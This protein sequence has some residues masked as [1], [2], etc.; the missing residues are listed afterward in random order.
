MKI[1]DVQNVLI[2]GS[3]TMGRQ[4]GLQCVLHGYA[5]TLYDIQPAALEAAVIQIKSY[6]DQMVANGASEAQVMA[7][8]GRINTTAS[9]A[10]AAADADLV[11]ES[12]LENPALKGEVFARLNAVCPAHTIFTTNTSSLK[13]SQFAAATGRPARFCAFHFHQPVWTSNVVDIMPHPGTSPEV[14]DLLLAFARC[15]DQIPIFLHKESAN[16]VFN[17]MLDAVLREAV[18]LAANDVASVEDI[19]RAWMGV[20]KMTIGPFGILDLVGLDLAW[21][22]TQRTTRWVSFLPQVRRIRNLIK[23]RVVQGKLGV[24]SKHGFYTYPHPVY[25]QPGF[26]SGEREPVMAPARD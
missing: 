11:S 13:P 22:I 23:Q 15:I 21:D 12:V 16:Y 17:A 1:E 5:V 7:A 2:V 19:D 24:K 25:Q 10:D 18:T 3:G 26:V 14:V 9:L 8:L 4:I 20:T 6:A